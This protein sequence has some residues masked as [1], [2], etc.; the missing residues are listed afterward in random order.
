M[1]ALTSSTDTES[2]AVL[3]SEDVDSVDTEGGSDGSSSSSYQRPVVS[4]LERL[5]SAPKAAANRKRKIALNLPHDGKRN[6]APRCASDPKGIT[7]AQ[8][9]AEYPNENFSASAKKLFC[10]ACREEVSLKKSVITLYIKSEKHSKGKIQLQS[11]NKREQNIVQALQ[12]YDEET[13]P[14]GETLPTEQR[15]Y[16]VKVV[17]TFLRAGVP[18]SK[19]EHFRPLLEEFGYRLAGRKQMSDLIPNHSW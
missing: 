13:Y 10:T 17:Q 4:L 3:N 5:R 6:K 15:V 16:R 11:K 9:V 18:I 2:T 12:K 14:V 19:I 8:R 1:A 7:A